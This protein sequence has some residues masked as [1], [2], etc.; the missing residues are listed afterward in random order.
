MSI[1]KLY[2]YAGK[3]LWVNLTTKNYKIIDTPIDL[4]KNFVG[5]RGFGARY[6]GIMLNLV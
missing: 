1:S 5:A 4:A 2:G 6:Y 3:I